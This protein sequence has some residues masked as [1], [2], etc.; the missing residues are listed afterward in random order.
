MQSVAKISPERLVFLDEC[1]F[2][3]ALYRL[4]GWAKKHDRCTESVPCQRGKNRSVLAAMSW[5]GVQA[6]V[7]QLGGF[8]RIDFEA[9]LR[10]ELLPVLAP[11][12]VLIFDNA[13]IHH[14]GEIT[15]I[16]EAAGCSITYLPPYSPDLNPIEMAWGWIKD[17]VRCATPREDAERIKEIESA[18]EAIPSEFPFAWF[19]NCGMLQ[20]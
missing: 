16:V 1:G 3:L 17:K 9:F 18:I 8:K 11:D 5:S 6:S 10:D 20:S 7:T 2:S 15:K 19:A 12:S 13:R 4:Y 14:G